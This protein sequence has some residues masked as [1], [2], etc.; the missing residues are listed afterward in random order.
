MR[1]I[2]ILALVGVSAASQAQLAISIGIRETG[3]TGAIGTNGGST[4][5]IEFVNLDGQ[6]LNI[7]GTWQTF[8]FNF[9]GDAL[10]AF[11]GGS[12]NSLYDGTRGVLEMIRI[13]NI[14]GNTNPLSV[15]V[16]DITS[17]DA[18]GNSV[19]FGSFEGFNA[20]Q[21]VMFQEPGFSGSTAAN[22]MAG[23]F[24]G[25]DDT[26]AL[27]GTNSYRGDF[28]F[29]DNSTTRW[30]RWTTFNT[31]QLGNPIIDFNQGS[32]LTF[33]MRAVPEPMTMTLLGAG[34]AALALRKKKR[35]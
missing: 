2:L 20:N 34:L 18:S 22:V 31:G 4:G 23:S 33:S 26:V 25:V 28:Q 32:T 14:N 13:R 17:T 11:A 8:T 30:I 21:E 9:Q 6:S 35:A 15:W 24:A 5:G 3:S 16:D 12:A 19:N 7:D 27:S 29:V 1:K 10:T